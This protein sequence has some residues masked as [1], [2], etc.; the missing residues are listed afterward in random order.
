MK[1]SVLITGIS[2]SGKTSLSLMLAEMGYVAHDMD[3]VEGLFSMRDRDT[4]KPVVGYDSND[5]DKVRRMRWICDV[6]RLK[7]L[8]SNSDSSLNFYCGAASNLFD[9]MSLF[10]AVI[11]LKATHDTTRS[12]LS[13]RTT[14]D[15]GRTAKIQDYILK[16]K[17][18][19]DNE[20]EKKGAIA[21][22]SNGSLAMVA[23]EVLRVVTAPTAIKPIDTCR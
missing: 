20:L 5:L 17:D 15:H 10:D 2:G 13:N 16:Y 1:L 23:A 3:S 19:W 14:S 11:L 8:L 21:V 9:L 4:M 12:R 22:D 18:W 7:A 6:D